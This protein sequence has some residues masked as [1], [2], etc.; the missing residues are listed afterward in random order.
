MVFL[1]AVDDVKD[2]LLKRAAQ[3]HNIMRFGRGG[4]SIMHFGKRKEMVTDGDHFD[5]LAQAI[6]ADSNS[7][8]RQSEPNLYE[9]NDQ[10]NAEPFIGTRY[11]I[12]R[13]FIG[14]YQIR[15]TILTKQSLL[16]SKLIEFYF[17]R[18]LAKLKLHFT[19][20]GDRSSRSPTTTETYSCISDDLSYSSTV[21]TQP[22]LL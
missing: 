12:P 19:L 22:L 8:E 20:V 4:H 9:Q 14:R 13:G 5:D 10:R 6:G 16:L 21:V 15:Y 1:I 17:S 3:S 18:V 11:V 7:L 2:E